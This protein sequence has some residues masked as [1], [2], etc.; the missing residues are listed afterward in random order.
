[1]TPCI[2][3][4][5]FP[6]PHTRGDMYARMA[7]VLRWTAERHCPAW[8]FVVDDQPPAACVSAMGIRSHEFNTQKDDSWCRAVE[9]APDGAQLLLLDVDTCIT[10][11]LDDVWTLDFDVAYTAR[12][13]DRV[14]GPPFNS[15]VLFVRVSQATRAFFRL[16]NTE[17]HRLLAD[18]AA[19]EPLR[20]RFTGIHQSALG[21]LL[22]QDAMPWLGLKA[23]PCAVWN[24]DPTFD[25]YDE[26]ATRILHVKSGFRRAVFGLP[27]MQYGQRLREVT[28]LW[29]ALE[30]EAL[31]AEEQPA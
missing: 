14:A 18:P 22:Q 9:Q 2:H 13:T 24:C 8:E 16:W 10:R 11:P 30:R 4:S 26:A 29:H 28:R 15:G 6:S 5:N 31:R 20:R 21:S 27:G 3:T 12:P 19:H 1:M 7:R 25:T 17:T 23:L